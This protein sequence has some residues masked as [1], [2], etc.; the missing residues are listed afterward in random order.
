MP[1]TTRHHPQRSAL[2]SC[3]ACGLCLPVCPTFRLT[4]DETASPRGRLA[5]M[6]LVDAAGVAVDDRFAEMMSLC[7]QCRACETACPSLVP[8]GEAMEGA[9]AEAEAQAPQGLQKI[10]RFGLTTVLRSRWLL[11]TITLVAALLQRAGLLTRLPVIGN[12]AMGLR[13]LPVVARTSAG[14]SWGSDGRPVAMLVSGCV[15]DVWCSAVHTAT[16]ELLVAAGY[17]VEA[18]ATQTCCGA[19][20]SHS[21]F[22]A[23]AAK[24]AERNIVAFRGAD[25]VVADVAGCGAHLKMYGRFGEA[26]VDLARRVRDINEVVAD[27]IADGRLPTLPQTG[28]SVAIQDPCHLEHGQ[29]AHT[30]VD[31]VV[32]AAGFEPVPVDR[33][34]LCCGAA[35]IYS[36]DEPVMAQRLGVAK[37]DA[38]TR[39]GVT[40][41]ATANIG[42]EMQLRRYLGDGYSVL[43][44]VEVYW[45][46]WRDA[47][48]P[49]SVQ[50]SAASHRPSA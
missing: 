17:R 24:M 20:A 8:F 30:S 46:Q 22:A 3:V 38:V 12:Q 26:G 9:R 32:A 48:G 42:C 23:D 39:S 50:S 45:R 49:Y 25:I 13:R 11:R 4:G 18:P 29:R 21:G 47:D 37:A 31:T 14:G 28:R 5:A 40:V 16:V 1:W 27:A 34:G 15:S 41:V 10:R 7:L 43:H 35:G 6:T 19:L 36:I 44:P 2:K 33:G